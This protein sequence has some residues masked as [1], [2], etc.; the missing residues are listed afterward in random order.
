MLTKQQKDLNFI[1]AYKIVTYKNSN[2]YKKFFI[3]LGI[4]LLIIVLASSIMYFKYNSLKAENIALSEKINTYNEIQKQIDSFNKIQVVYKDKK[5]AFDTII[6]QNQTTLNVLNTL[7]EN[8]PSQ[9]NIESL[10][11]NQNTLSF[12]VNY[13]DEKGITEFLNNLQKV[14]IINSVSIDGINSNGSMKRTSINAQ[15][16][17][18]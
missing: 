16:T 2:W 5:A 6:N 3:V 4:E 18:K 11:I 13:K 8:M 15:I 10:S 9:M 12:I 14:S 1:K 7:E 17:G